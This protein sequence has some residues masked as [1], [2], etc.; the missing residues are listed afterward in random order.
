MTTA[1][2]LVGAVYDL[3]GALPDKFHTEG[4]DG[5]LTAVGKFL[6]LSGLGLGWLCPAAIGLVIG[7]AIR[8]IRRRN[9]EKILK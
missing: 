6:P 7:L 3:L 4:F 9:A 5:F 8:L 1:F 2:T